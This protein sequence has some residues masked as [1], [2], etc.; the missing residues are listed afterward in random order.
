MSEITP[1]NSDLNT[2]IKSAIVMIAVAGVAL[3]FGGWVFA[4]LVAAIAVG[5]IGEW[6]GLSQ[7]IAQDAAGRFFWLAV[8]ALYVGAASYGLIAL[9][10]TETHQLL[11]VIMILSVVIATDVGAYFTGRS[12]G[13]PKIAPSIS[14]SKTWS[15]LL[16]GMTLAGL[17]GIGFAKWLNAPSAEY[18]LFAI[19]G[20][21]MAVLAQVGDFF[22]SWMKRRAGVKDASNFIPGHGGLLDRMDGILPVVLASYF[23][24]QILLPRWAN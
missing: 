22:E 15:G 12:L 16:G 23:I 14:P 4:A 20:L 1:Q 9:R 18:A 10:G 3:W 6:W 21:T 17:V 13:G 11:L 2:R 19:Y 24:F 5:L 7:K 8:G